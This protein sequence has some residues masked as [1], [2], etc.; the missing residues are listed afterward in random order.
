MEDTNK[1]G[2]KNTKPHGIEGVD[3][4]VSCTHSNILGLENR[5]MPKSRISFTIPKTQEERKEI[6]KLKRVQFTQHEKDRLSA[7]HNRLALTIYK[8]VA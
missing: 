3:Y 2:D 4:N 5:M 6:I 8:K 1:K 7:K